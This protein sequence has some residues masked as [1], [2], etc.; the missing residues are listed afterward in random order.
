M[1]QLLTSVTRQ[2]IRVPTVLAVT[3]VLSLVV[4]SGAEAVS[5]SA[6]MLSGCRVRKS[7]RWFE[8]ASELG[9]SR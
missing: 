6:P 1:R 4:S 2:P 8:S 3:S 7:I 9:R 5:P